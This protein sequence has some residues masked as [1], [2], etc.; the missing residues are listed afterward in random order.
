MSPVYSY[1]RTYDTLYL[2]LY[3]YY[4]YRHCFHS[5]LLV[6]LL[7]LYSYDTLK[8]RCQY[9]YDSINTTVKMALRAAV[10]VFFVVLVRCPL[11]VPAVSYY[12]CIPDTAVPGTVVRNT[13]TSTSRIIHT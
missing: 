6:P 3:E 8:L 2:V 4:S 13:R 11:I 5:L 12:E 10:L 7:L 9:E 1:V